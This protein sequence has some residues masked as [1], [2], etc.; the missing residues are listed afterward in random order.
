MAVKIQSCVQSYAWFWSCPKKSELSRWT[1]R[2]SPCGQLHAPCAI[3]GRFSCLLWL[4]PRRL[5]IYWSITTLLDF[6]VKS[7]S[8]KFFSL[9]IMN[10]LCFLID[11]FQTTSAFRSNFLGRQSRVR[12]ATFESSD[13]SVSSL[14]FFTLI[15]YFFKQVLRL[16]ERNT[17]PWFFVPRTITWS[18]YVFLRLICDLAYQFAVAFIRIESL[19]KY[20]NGKY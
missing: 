9:D 5:D 15:T 12:S 4:R 10:L 6:L 19:M 14:L 7:Y 20:W 2:S 1:L 8:I 11:I 13:Y 3:P 17:R 18:D 16:S